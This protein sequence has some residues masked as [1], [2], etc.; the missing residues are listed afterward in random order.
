RADAIVYDAHLEIPTIPIT[1]FE[2]Q[3]RKYKEFKK[4][5]TKVQK[6]L[7]KKGNGYNDWFACCAGIYN[8]SKRLGFT[9]PR[10]FV[11]MFSKSLEKYDDA[12]QKSI[13]TA[14]YEKSDNDINFLKKFSGSKKGEFTI[15]SNTISSIQPR[16]LVFRDDDES[17]GND[18]D[19]EPVV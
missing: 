1:Y 13:D 3:D 11:H 9:N 14:D 15:N 17:D 2:E 7:K 16:N 5:L 19:N 10:H 12:A 8:G 4:L 6:T 18:D